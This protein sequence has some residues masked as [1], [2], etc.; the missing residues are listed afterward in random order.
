M[1]K[2]D[3]V[4]LHAEGETGT[5]GWL[6]MHEA[7]AAQTFGHSA[8]VFVA[9]YDVALITLVMYAGSTACWQIISLNTNMRNINFFNGSAHLCSSG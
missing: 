7:S 1:L 4:S 3:T 8:G 2:L 6:T 5:I 9:T